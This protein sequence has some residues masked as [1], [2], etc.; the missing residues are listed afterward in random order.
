MAARAERLSRAFIRAQGYCR[1]R[2]RS[3]LAAASILFVVFSLFA[4]F[5]SR[6]AV[7]LEDQLDP[8]L[9]SSR[10][11]LEMKEAFPNDLNVGLIVPSGDLCE[12]EGK[13]H[14]LQR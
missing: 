3:V 9:R 11:L 12:L 10:D 7:M 1:K 13:V 6:Q 5:R 14:E 2:S 8:S 4:A